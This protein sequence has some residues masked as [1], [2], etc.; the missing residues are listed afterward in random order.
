[1]ERMGAKRSVERPLPAHGIRRTEIGTRSEFFQSTQTA[2]G[3]RRETP[4]EVYGK[5]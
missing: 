3:A 2:L 5:I 1:M 4:D